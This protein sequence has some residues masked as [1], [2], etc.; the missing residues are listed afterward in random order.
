[1]D[2]NI[3]Q[4]TQ[5]EI[6]DQAS[7]EIMKKWPP[8]SL[9]HLIEQTGKL[10]NEIVSVEKKWSA[11]KSNIYSKYLLLNEKV[12]SK[13]K[14]AYEALYQDQKDNNYF[15]KEVLMIISKVEIFINN[16][17][18]SFTG[19]ELTYTLGFQLEEK[20]YEY[21]LTLE[22][23]LKQAK[24]GID[25]HS[26]DLKMRLDVGKKT[27]RDNLNETKKTLNQASTLFLSLLDFY[28]SQVGEVQIKSGKNK[29]K[30]RVV[31]GVFGEGENKKRLNLGQLYELYRF[32][33]V[34]YNYSSDYSFSISN[35]NDQTV[36]YS[37]LKR[38]L[39]ST[40]GRKGGD[41]GDSQ[42]KFHGA[43]FGMLSSS[44]RDLKKIINILKDLQKTKDINKFKS[45]IKQMFT[46]E[47]QTV[48]SAIEKESYEKAVKYVETELF[49]K[50]KFL[51]K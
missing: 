39:N 38:V 26:A 25:S 21:E 46:R 44:Y 4:M 9:K 43:S 29:G 17:R 31:K 6:V 10:M 50:N 19:E 35:E 16:I 12:T 51:L 37:L 7:K 47:G 48:L 27:L 24:V 28:N 1:M 5:N 41:V 15:Y 14:V 42:V 3:K 11:R 40:S 13:T 45:S 8:K 2:D 18:K 32:L 36:F 34:E 49:K 30:T 20:L 23:I 33:I 22:E